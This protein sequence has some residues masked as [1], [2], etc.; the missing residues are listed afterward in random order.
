[1]AFIRTG[2]RMAG[3]AY[4]AQIDPAA[5]KSIP[6]PRWPRNWPETGFEFEEIGSA[7]GNCLRRFP[8]RDLTGQS[9]PF[10]MPTLWMSS[11][12]SPMTPYRTIC[13]RTQAKLYVA[14][15][16]AQ[17]RAAPLH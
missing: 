14:A 2:S 3:Y 1:M 11:G 12:G 5:L 10:L 4:K 16:I 15:R 13:V 17:R 9:L 7:A 8:Q 6:L